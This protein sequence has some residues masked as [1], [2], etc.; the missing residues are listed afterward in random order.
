MKAQKRRVGLRSR[1]YLLNEGSLA[2]LQL[3][4]KEACNQH[5]PKASKVVFWHLQVTAFTGFKE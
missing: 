4:A 2:E 3:E 1:L 5:H